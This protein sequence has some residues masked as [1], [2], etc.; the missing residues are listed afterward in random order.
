MLKRKTALLFLILLV[1]SLQWGCNTNPYKADISDIDIEPVQI[2]RYGKSL[3]EMDK[4]NVG[5]GLEEL[6]DRFRFFLGDNYRDTL[7]IIQISEFINDPFNL[8]IADECLKQ[9]PDLNAIEEDFTEAFSYFKYHFPEKEIPEVYSYISGLSYENP[10][11]YYDSVLILA[12]DLYLGKDFDGYRQVGLPFYQVRRMEP[13]SI[14]PDCFTEMAMASFAEPGSMNTLLDRMV[15]YGKVLYFLDNMLPETPDE[16]KI[17][18]TPEQLQWCIENENELWSFIINND[19]LYSSD[20]HKI[21]Q[22]IQDGPFTNGFGKES[23][24]MTGRWLG[25]QIVRE[26]A[27]NN[28]KMP[29]EKILQNTD[30]QGILQSSGYK[31][32]RF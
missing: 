6:S 16:H 24:A 8:K 17:G 15:Y 21:N 7:G 12:L 2:H 31:P 20:Y 25:W 32:K 22:L 29:L 23:P 4:S 1:V 26:Y 11:G 18:F 5:K 14:L 10:A 30:S 9:Y 28:P 19:L 13:H 3:F 27:L